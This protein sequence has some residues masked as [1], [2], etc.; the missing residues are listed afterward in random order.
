M[1]IPGTGELRLAPEASVPSNEILARCYD[2]RVSKDPKVPP[3]GI[4]E[5]LRG[6]ATTSLVLGARPYGERDPKG[7]NCRDGQAK[8]LRG[9]AP[10]T[11]GQS[12]VPVASDLAVARGGVCLDPQTLRRCKVLGRRS[13]RLAVHTQQ[14]AR[15]SSVIAKAAPGSSS[16][17]VARALGLALGH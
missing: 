9:W 17:V 3:C 5:R 13:A 4:L 11:F 7:P 6:R 12:Q 15:R 1:S 2:E 8:R 10:R 14:H 16:G